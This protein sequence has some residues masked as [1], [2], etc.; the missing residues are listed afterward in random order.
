SHPDVTL[1]SFFGYALGLF[2]VNV[3]HNIVHLLF[4]VWGLLA[5]KSLPAA[6]N[7]ARSV[8]IIYAVLM[9]AGLIPGLD[10]MFGLVPLFGNDVWL[11]A[12][13]AAVAAYFGWM[14]RDRA[15][16]RR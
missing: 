1:D 7:Y 2:P 10:T 14:H 5:Y 11:H 16:D 8:A 15:T 9:V 3:L 13:L 4:G 12:L 6:K